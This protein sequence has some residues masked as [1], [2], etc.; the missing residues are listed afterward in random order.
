VRAASDRTVLR[1]MTASFAST[2]A[3]STSRSRTRWGA[4]LPV[5]GNPTGPGLRT[6]LCVC[7][8]DQFVSRAAHSGWIVATSAHGRPGARASKLAHYA[9]RHGA[10]PTGT[11]CGARPARIASS[12]S[13]DLERCRCWKTRS[14]LRAPEGGTRPHWRV[15]SK[16]DFIFHRGPQ[17]R[18]H[19]D[20]R[21][22]DP[23]DVRAITSYLNGW[24]HYD[25]VPRSVALT[26]G[27]P[28][29]RD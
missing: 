2:S 22:V 10:H 21:L 27:P 1:P 20:G 12:N 9:K 7:E 17:F 16:V 24:D 11:C 18:K 8:L 4:R 14:N 26:G 5:S 3:C 28:W 15:S 6:G 25:D 23:P 13:A 29:V 19:E